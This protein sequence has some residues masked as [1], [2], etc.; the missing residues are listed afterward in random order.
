M[1]NYCEC[2]LYVSGP[3]TRLEEFFREVAG[4]ESPF[5]FN[6]L[7]PYPERF[8]E[9]DR[10][11]EE[12]WKKAPEERTDSCPKDGF[13]QGG[14]EWRVEHWGTKWNACGVR[15]DRDECPQDGAADDCFTFSFSTPWSP[16]TPVI[17]HAAA[18]FPELSFDLFYFESGAG[19][20]GKFTCRDGRVMCDEMRPYSGSRGG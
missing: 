10:L 3:K 5:D 2:D 4:E 11:A 19:F 7:I 12:W 18:R 15:L 17:E 6:R 20:R 16:P 1:P 13:N 8:R 14:Y 9:R